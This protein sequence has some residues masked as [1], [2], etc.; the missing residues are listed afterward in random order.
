[1]FGIVRPKG[2]NVPVSFQTSPSSLEHVIRLALSQ[3]TVV[4]SDR[5]S[6]RQLSR[7]RRKA[8]H[9]M[10]RGGEDQVRDAGREVASFLRQFDPRLTTK[11]ASLCGDEV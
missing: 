9:A 7:L 3:S 5:T 10:H 4:V 6:K 11:L 8:L 1:M 2:L